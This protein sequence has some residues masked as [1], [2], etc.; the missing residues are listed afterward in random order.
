MSPADN[1]YSAPSEVVSSLTAAPDADRLDLRWVF[2]GLPIPVLVFG[3][4]L[5]A[6]AFVGLIIA[7][8]FNY[9]GLGAISISAAM[10]LALRLAFFGTIGSV[11]VFMLAAVPLVVF[12]SRG[13][14]GPFTAFGVLLGTASLIVGLFGALLVFQSLTNGST[15]SAIAVGSLVFL[16]VVGVPIA[17][18]AFSYA[19]WIRRLRGQ[20]RQAETSVRANARHAESVTNPTG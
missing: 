2:V 16:L 11:F 15:N 4:F 20:A 1:P 5:A 13:R 19:W 14:L 17:M 6:S 9:E 18:S 7:R 12:N 8:T 10:G 3:M